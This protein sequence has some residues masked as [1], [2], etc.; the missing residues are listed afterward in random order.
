MSMCDVCKKDKPNVRM[1]NVWGKE[2]ADKWVCEN[3]GNYKSEAVE[4]STSEMTEQR[5]EYFNSILQPYRGGEVSKEF[6]EAHPK[7]AKKMFTKEQIKNSKYI[8]SDLK[9]WDNRK[10]S[11]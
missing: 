1:S 4:F 6:I 5:Q 7:K 10:K 8:W 11:K 2:W 3:C 9:G